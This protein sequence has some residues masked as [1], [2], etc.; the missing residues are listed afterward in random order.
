MP[1]RMFYD[2][3]AWEDKV[4]SEDPIPTTLDKAKA[5]LPEALVEEGDFFG[6][7]DDE[8]TVL[9]FLKEHG[10]VWMEVPSPNDGGSYGKRITL[11]EAIRAI[12][13]L[14]ETIERVY[15]DGLVF[16]KW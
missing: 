4:S 15:M 1:Y 9:Q 14:G 12:D 11:E 10:G 6:L 8:D 5:I 13:E 2:C 7:V 3:Y 16:E